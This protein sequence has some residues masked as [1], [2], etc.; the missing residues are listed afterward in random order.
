M[1][2]SSSSS[3]QTTTEVGPL[4]YMAPESLLERTY[5][6]KSDVWAFGI[7]VMEIITRAEPYPEFDALMA[8]T[9][10]THGLRPTIPSNVHP[11]LQTLLTDCWKTS[12]TD[13]P[14]FEKV[15]YFSPTLFFSMLNLTLSQICS[16]L[17]YIPSLTKK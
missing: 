11:D 15:F 6:S 5:S 1:T 2:E 3:A 13:R 12:P 16:R 4:K 10:V 14:D 7:T 17:E 9:K 8:A